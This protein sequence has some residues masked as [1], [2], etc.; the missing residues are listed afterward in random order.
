MVRAWTD[1]R[2]RE[3]SGRASARGGP[4]PGCE[5]TGTRGEARGCAPRSAAVTPAL[6]RL[7]RRPCSL[8]RAAAAA[9]VVTGLLPVGLPGLLA[10]TRKCRVRV[11]LAVGRVWTLVVRPRLLSPVVLGRR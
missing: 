11:Y 4:G 6:R 9:A 2:G 7:P 10:G 1:G 8:R 3:G 5:A